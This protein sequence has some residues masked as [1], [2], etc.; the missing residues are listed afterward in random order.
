MCMAFP[1]RKKCY[2]RHNN[3]IFP[4]IKGR[5]TTFGH[6]FNREKTMH[7]C[8]FNLIG[9]IVIQKELCHLSLEVTN[10]HARLA[11]KT[12]EKN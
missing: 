10:I 9:L 6:N 4:R 11:V 3:P 2:K 8:N 5:V 1:M 7:N 12:G